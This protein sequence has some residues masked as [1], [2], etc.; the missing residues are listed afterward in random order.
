MERYLLVTEQT[1]KGRRKEEPGREGEDGTIR[2]IWSSSRVFKII[3]W[4]L[5]SKQ[6]TAA[7]AAKKNPERTFNFVVGS[8]HVLSMGADA[9]STYFSISKQIRSEIQQKKR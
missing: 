9:L 8:S 4:I 7:A 3:Y 2:T 6:Q 5:K 1:A